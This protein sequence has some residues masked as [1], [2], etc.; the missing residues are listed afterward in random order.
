[1]AT[2]CGGPEAILDARS[3]ILVAPRDPGALADAV[4][5]I[6]ESPSLAHELAQAACQRARE[7]FSLQTMLA[8]YAAL[9]ETVAGTAR[10]AIPTVS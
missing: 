10:R 2:R 8:R 4:E 9:I 6:V 3:G 1:V 5:R 7:E